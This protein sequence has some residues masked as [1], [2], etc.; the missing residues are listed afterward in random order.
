[1]CFNMFRDGVFVGE[2]VWQGVCVCCSMFIG[3]FGCD[4]V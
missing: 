3:I 1:M 2:F 4:F